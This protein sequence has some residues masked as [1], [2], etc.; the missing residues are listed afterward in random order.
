MHALVNVGKAIGLLA[1]LGDAGLLGYSTYYVKM[2]VKD[3]LQSAYVFNYVMT[4]VMCIMLIPDSMFFMKN[5]K[6]KFA[7]LDGEV[8]IGPL[9]RAAWYF[10][11]GTF[12]ITDPLFSIVRSNEGRQDPEKTIFVSM[13]VGAIAFGLAGVVTVVA[14]ALNEKEGGSSDGSGNTAELSN[15]DGTQG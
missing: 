15:G 12:I 4:F 11:L 2:H 1:L 6:A 9:I 14:A 5:N 10:S 3:P 13:V 7:K 8:K